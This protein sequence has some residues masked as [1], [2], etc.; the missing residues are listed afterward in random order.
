M[1]V[2]RVWINSMLGAIGVMTDPSGGG[3]AWK[4]STHIWLFEL[5]THGGGK[6]TLAF[7]FRVKLHEMLT[8]I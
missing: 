7:V 3:S 1:K 8:I 2:F 6:K 5:Y 4:K